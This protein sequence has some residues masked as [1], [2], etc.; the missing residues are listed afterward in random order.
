M[1]G[2]S[3]MNHW[4]TFFKI[5]WQN[6]VNSNFSFVFLSANFSQIYKEID[7]MIFFIKCPVCRKNI[8]EFRGTTFHF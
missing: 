6:V 4:N 7:G 3:F 1:G 8:S 5:K 2:N